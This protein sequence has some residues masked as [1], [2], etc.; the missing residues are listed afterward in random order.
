MAQTYDCSLTYQSPRTRL[1]WASC[2]AGRHCRQRQ[3]WRCCACTASLDRIASFRSRRAQ[4]RLISTII[5]YTILA[6]SWFSG[7]KVR[8]PHYRLMRRLIGPRMLVHDSCVLVYGLE[9]EARWSPADA[10]AT[11]ERVGTRAHDLQVNCVCH[12]TSKVFPL[13]RAQAT[14]LLFHIPGIGGGFRLRVADAVR[15]WAPPALG[16]R[17]LAACARPISSGRTLG[18]WP[19]AFDSEVLPTQGS[20]THPP[21]GDAPRLRTP[22]SYGATLSL[23][24]LARCAR[25]A[26]GRKYA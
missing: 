17:A 7:R 1:A 2:V 10:A 20:T 14:A 22:L 16:A 9:C 26:G 8:A 19:G 5:E 23:L 13:R 6:R 11:P 18:Q 3:C 12:H 24:G 15:P 4:P 21:V 25:A